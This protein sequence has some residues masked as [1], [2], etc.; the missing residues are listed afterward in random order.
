MA[1][2]R[3]QQA[4][5]SHFGCQVIIKRGETIVADE[6]GPIIV[7]TRNDDLESVLE[8]TPPQRREGQKLQRQAI[9][10]T[11]ILPSPQHKLGSIALIKPPS[12]RP[13]L[14]PEWNAGAL[15]GREGSCR[16]YTGNLSGFLTLFKKHSCMFNP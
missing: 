4:T 12:C 3:R 13:C 8:A 2:P 14:H 9:A 10:S 1:Y 16:Q 6:G 5:L 11:R 7:C 15:A